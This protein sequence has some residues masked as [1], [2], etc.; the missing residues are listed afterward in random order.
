MGDEILIRFKLYT[1]QYLR[2]DGFYF[3]EFKILGFSENLNTSNFQNDP[4]IIYPTI[5]ENNIKINSSKNIS[6]ILI[7]NSLGKKVLEFNANNI[8]EIN[9]N[10]IDA[11][12]YFI[13]L[14]DGKNF[15]NR[16]LIKK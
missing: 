15:I 8:L 1:D 4:V 6:K 7:H 14:F 9:L 5:V 2:Q 16:K 13:K 12:V 10:E 11:G 3:D